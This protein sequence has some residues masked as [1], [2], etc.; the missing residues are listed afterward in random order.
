MHFEQGKKDPR[1]YTRM[2][3]FAMP[4][5]G[6]QQEDVASK[7]SE[8]PPSKCAFEEYSSTTDGG[9]RFAAVAA[10]FGLSPFPTETPAK[11]LIDAFPA[12]RARSLCTALF[13]LLVDS[14]FPHATSSVQAADHST[15]HSVFASEN[16][17]RQ[18]GQLVKAHD[19]EGNKLINRYTLI[20]ILGRGAYGKVKL[21]VDESNCPVAIKS[22]RKNYL[23]KIDG[24]NGIAREIAVMKKLKHRNVVPLYE[25]IDDPESEKLYM[26]MKYVDQGPITKLQPGGTC[27]TIGAERLREVLGELVS[28]LSYLH[29]RGVAHRDIKPDNILV[30]AAGTPYFVDFG[31]SAII[32]RNNPNV[33][34]VEGTATFMPPELFDDQALKVDAFAADVWSL[35]VTVYML[36]YGKVPFGGNNY[37]EISINVRSKTLEFP[38]ANGVDSSRWEDLLRGML[39]RDPAKRMKLKTVKKHPAVL[40]EDAPLTLEELQHATARATNFI[41]DPFGVREP[42]PIDDDGTVAALPARCESSTRA[43]AGQPRPSLEGSFSVNGRMVTLASVLQPSVPLCARRPVVATQPTIIN[44]HTTIGTVRTTEPAGHHKG[45]HSQ[46]EDEWLDDYEGEGD[47]PMG[48]TDSKTQVGPGTRRPRPSK[49]SSSSVIDDNCA[50][51]FDRDEAAL[52]KQRVST[53]IIEE[54]EPAVEMDVADATRLAVSSVDSQQAPKSRLSTSSVEEAIE[55]R[56]DDAPRISEGCLAPS[57]PRRD[58][59]RMTT[60]RL[61]TSP[62]AQQTDEKISS[63]AAGDRGASHV[64]RWWW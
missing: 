59:G 30:D 41:Q 19:V 39:C 64:R 44:S 54:I 52:P 26:V 25:V 9:S 34:T 49:R 27:E 1:E 40:Q 62:P 48:R 29:K 21:A 32:D 6:Q 42:T 20:Q 13:N 51:V 61:S 47:Q 5:E 38:A 43:A 3:R 57:P 33:S 15:G 63:S 2:L 14:F 56:V 22:V 10:E 7:H 58:Q 31:V 18:T 37:R 8:T 46:P 35:G 16:F 45:R 53:S 55:P 28:G 17:V 11:K 60:R 4:S 50:V 36:L 24:V 23:K 12:E